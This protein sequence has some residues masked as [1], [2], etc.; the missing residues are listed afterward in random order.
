[1]KKPKSSAIFDDKD[2]P[3]NL[4]RKNFFY[5]TGY[6]LSELS[7][8]PIIGIVNS[9]TDMNPGHAHL[10]TI[11]HRVKEGVHA[12]G[13]IPFEF[14]VP[15][16]CD[17]MTEGHEGMR[18]VLAQRDLIADIVETHVRSM[19]YDGLVFIASCDKIIPGM[20]MAAGR[21][22]LPAI[23]ITGGPNA[24]LIRFK[25]VMKV[26]SS[27]DN[28]S[29]DDLYDKLATGTCATC[30]A[31]ELMG[32]AN[33]MQCL[34][35]A[36]GLS[37]PRSASVPAYATEKLMYARQAGKR[38]VSMVEEGITSDKIL[39]MKAIENAVMVDLAIGGSTNSTLHLPAIAHA[40]GLELPLAAFNEFNKKIPT[41]C[42]VWP[43]GPHGIT[44]LYIAGGIPAVMKRLADSLHLDALTADGKTVGD[45]VNEAQVLDDTVIR[46]RTNAVLSEG[47][48]VVLFGNLAP[49]GAVIK[50]SAVSKDMHVFTGKAVVFESEADC[51]QAIR[52]GRM[53][54]GM[55]VVIRN[56]GPKGGPGMPETLAITMWIEMVGLKRI[57][58][59]TDGRFS[60]ASS[61]PCVGHV[62]PEAASGGPIAA[63]R[64]GDEITVDIP[65]RRIELKLSADEIAKRLKAWKPVERDIPAGY[66]RRYVKLVGPASKGA[67]LD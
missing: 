52:E 17:G 61:G 11:A 5:G 30:G 13:G 50:Q 27:I 48:T 35:E 26:K 16:P 18:F 53:T 45:V 21:L 40:C 32:T 60:G 42:S 33:T 44:D 62:T 14:G 10:D 22:K 54:E 7:E 39:T 8:K 34:T 43:N 3:I 59:I 29:Y 28:K 41:L 65:G 9:Q 37:I 55:V 36:L 19:L 49:E 1:M 56:E 47:S 23:F 4:V 2:V 46:D 25:P 64:D 51:L 58:L 15:A 66:M 38:I 67:V 24:M 57:A 20:I 12:A 31:C 63:V 6:E